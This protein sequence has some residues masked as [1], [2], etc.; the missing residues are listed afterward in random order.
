MNEKRK[1]K[2]APIPES[3]VLDSSALLALWNDEEGADIVADLFHSRKKIYLSFM[4]L[5]ECRY[6]I[7]K[8]I[9]RNEA[10]KFSAY[11]DL[12]PVE[13][14]WVSEVIFEKAVE[15]KANH[16]LSVCDSWIIAAAIMT[17]SLLVHK[18]P[19]F[20]Q[21]KDLLPLKPLPYKPKKTFSPLLDKNK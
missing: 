14:L 19:E 20:D 15:I 6:R 12:L 5:M 4:T 8:N 9:D 10:E 21:V 11:L 17:S 1:N 18:D 16:N 7:W 2:K 3:V 13:I